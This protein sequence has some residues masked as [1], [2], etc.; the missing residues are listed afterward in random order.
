[1]SCLKTNAQFSSIRKKKII[2]SGAVQLDSLSIVPQ[3]FSALDIDTSFYFIDYINSLLQWKKK[4]QVDS[5][6]VTYRVFSFKLNAVAQRYSYDSV[7]NN[8]IATPST[9]L[10]DNNENTLF[11]FGKLNYN[12]SFGRSISFG[13]SQD[14]VFNS[15]F[16]LQLNG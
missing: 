10:S 2:T 11:N 1:L 9:A 4:L 5:I 6:V 16:N 12:G 8:F 3:T 13:N 7:R 14:A 15:Q